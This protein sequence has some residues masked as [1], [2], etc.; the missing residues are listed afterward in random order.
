MRSQEALHTLELEFQVVVSCH[1]GPGNNVGALEQQQMLLI[2]E[3][4]IQP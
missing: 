1:V 4:S 3:L 2:I